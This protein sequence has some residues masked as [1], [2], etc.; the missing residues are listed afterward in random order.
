[1]KNRIL[2]MSII[3]VLIAI[4]IGLGSCVGSH[5]KKNIIA[6]GF[7]EFILFKLKTEL[8][9]TDAQSETLKQIA[10]EVKE[11]MKT[12]HGNK[13]ENHEKI[14]GLITSDYVSPE[15]VIALIDSH[16]PQVEEMKIFMAQKIAEIHGLLTPEQRMKLVE[17]L[18]K[19]AKEGH[20]MGNGF[21]H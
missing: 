10:E 11:K 12:L 7:H 3:V 5:G 13:E 14:K 17:F 2:V 9:L 20:G 21:F 19:Q 16:L 8:N 15:D 1:M 18:E 4:I 6:H